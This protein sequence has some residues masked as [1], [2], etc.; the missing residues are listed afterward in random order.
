M[1]SESEGYK[2]IVFDITSFSSYSK[3]LELLEWGYNRD[4]EEL[5]QINFGVIMGSPSS[6]PIGYRIYPGSITDVVTLK[7]LIEYL[8]QK[9]LKQ[10]MFW[11]ERLF[12]MFIALILH[13]ALSNRM[14][15]KEMYKKYTLSEVLYELKKIKVVEMLNG[16]R[17]LTE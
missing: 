9:G 5:R 16:K 14:K 2:G 17:Y 8:R 11:N 4:G 7:N 13:T 6:L 10:Y 3:N 15:E 1:A 12:V